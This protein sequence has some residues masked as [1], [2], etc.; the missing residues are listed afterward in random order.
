MCTRSLTSVL[1]RV[2]GQRHSPATLDPGKIPGTYCTGRCA[3]SRADLDGCGKLNLNLKRSVVHPAPCSVRNVGFY[4][5]LK[6]PE[7]EAYHSLPC[8]AEVK[9]E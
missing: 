3:G 1:E 7:R 5:G 9:N 4:P 6:R 8:S 2:S